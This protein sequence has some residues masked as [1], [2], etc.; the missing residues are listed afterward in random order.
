M[1][2]IDQLIH[3]LFY[4]FGENGINVA[5]LPDIYVSPHISSRY[6]GCDK[7]L[8]GDKRITLGARND[9]VARNAVDVI[10]NLGGKVLRYPSWRV[11]C[12]DIKTHSAEAIYEGYTIEVA[13]ELEV[14]HPIPEGVEIYRY[15][16][17]FMRPDKRVIYTPID[18][19]RV[20]VFC[21]DDETAIRRMIS[22]SMDE[23]QHLSE[24]HAESHN[25][26][27][28]KA[29]VQRGRSISNYRLEKLHVI[30]ADPFIFYQTFYAV[31]EEIKEMNGRYYHHFGHYMRAVDNAIELTMLLLDMG[32]ELD[33]DVVVNG[34]AV[35]DV[36]IKNGSTGHEETGVDIVKG[37]DWLSKYM[38]RIRLGVLGTQ[39]TNTPPRY[40]PTTL[41]A[42]IIRDAD[43]RSFSDNGE[44]FLIGNLQLIAEFGVKDPTKW[45]EGTLFMLRSHAI[46]LTQP[47]DQAPLVPFAYCTKPARQMWSNGVT[48]NIEVWERMGL[49]FSTDAIAA[50]SKKRDMRFFPVYRY[51]LR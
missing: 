40:P 4:V 48:S 9:V 34:A 6:N 29:L 31:L 44:Y 12:Y 5:Y 23:R 42:Q 47:P 14:K 28:V 24:R 22:S 7:V 10:Q 26:P 51:Y 8:Y 25:G 27:L 30:D 15:R 32:H 11:N 16:N 17:G 21:K 2:Q 45:Y 35:H 43:Q 38:D 41:E 19:L 39:V 37:W 1:D 20:P 36:G 33:V 46:A 49:Q 18:D 50:I 3:D 13:D